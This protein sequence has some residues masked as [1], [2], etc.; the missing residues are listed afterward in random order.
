MQAGAGTNGRYQGNAN[1][2][3]KDGRWARD[4][5]GNLNVANNRTRTLLARD[6]YDVEGTNYFRQSGNTESDRN[7][8][9]GRLGV[10]HQVS[11]RS[12]LS[13]SGNVRGRAYLNNDELAYT[14]RDGAQL[15]LRGGEQL[16]ASENAGNDSGA[17]SRSV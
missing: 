5:S 4:L 8:Y 3:V 10:E 16:N 7:N 14:E 1:I 9:G 12:T 6:S 2:N 11:N 13:M 17:A 15:W